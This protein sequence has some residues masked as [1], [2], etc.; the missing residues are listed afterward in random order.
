[1]A[2]DNALV[3]RVFGAAIVSVGTG[4]NNALETLGYTVDGVT[5]RERYALKPIMTDVMGPEIPGEMQKFGIELFSE[6]PLIS[7]NP[8]VW[9]KVQK[10]SAN[11]TTAGQL[12]ASGTL[13][14]TGGFTFKVGITSADALEDSFYMPTCVIKEPTSRKLASAHN[15]LVLQLHGTAFHLANTTT[16]TNTVAWSRTLG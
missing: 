10:R 15:P 1:M 7:W 13:V 9:E 6:V 11:N 12:A 16:V 5:L 4:T 8:T 3:Y 14:F 2:L